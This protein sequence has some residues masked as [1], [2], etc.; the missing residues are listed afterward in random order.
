[1]SLLDPIVRQILEAVRDTRVL[2]ATRAL[3][4]RAI[5]R[6]DQEKA[7]RERAR[8]ARAA[9]RAARPKKKLGGATEHHAKARRQE[10]RDAED[11]TATCWQLVLLRVQRD[12]RLLLCCEACHKPK[13]I[14]PHHLMMGAGGRVDEPELV[15][16]LCRDCHTLNP[17]SAHRAPR[18][19][20]QSIVIPWAARHGFTLPNR[21]EY[22][23]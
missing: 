18:T 8:E 16:A 14:E 2:E 10:E 20:A 6:D 22:R 7:D 5:E 11:V 9:A 15:M 23:Q 1:M 3:A 17:R 13:P 21:K 4:R 12:H 19:F